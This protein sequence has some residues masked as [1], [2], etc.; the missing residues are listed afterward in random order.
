MSLMILAFP[1]SSSIPLQKGL[2]P[3]ISPLEGGQ[4]GSFSKR[5]LLEEKIFCALVY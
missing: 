5:E 2:Y 3:K 1:I 4:G